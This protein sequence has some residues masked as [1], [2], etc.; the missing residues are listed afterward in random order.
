MI[1][2]KYYIFSY[3][4]FDKLLYL[5]YNININ[6]DYISINLIDIINMVKLPSL[7]NLLNTNN[8]IIDK[9]NNIIK[10]ICNNNINNN[11]YN[12]IPANL[13][14]PNVYLDPIPFTIPFY[15]KNNLFFIQSNVYYF[16][17]S[18]EKYS[19]QDKCDSMNVGIGFGTNDST[20]DNT[21]IG[22]SNDTIG[23]NSFNGV[24][25]CFTKKDYPYKK[26]NYGDTVGAG[27]IYKENNIYEFF[28]TLNGKK[29]NCSYQLYIKKKIIPVVSFTQYA[30]IYIN[31]N[32]SIFKYNYTHDIT[33]IVLS[34]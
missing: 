4:N 32:T 27:V 33:P 9:T 16:E 23:Y 8:I 11:I 26:F 14:L 29:I 6:Q 3:F 30:K 18:I 25:S 22:W 20:L 7:L 28:F 15:T 21:M 5:N 31:F 13:F 24:I 12:I 1:L 10:Y 2:S 17:I 34:I 19:S